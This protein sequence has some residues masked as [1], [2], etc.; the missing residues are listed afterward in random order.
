MTDKT[1][2]SF[3]EQL[4]SRTFSTASAAT[5]LAMPVERRLSGKQILEFLRDHTIA[6]I[7]TVRKDGRPHLTMGYFAMDDEGRF[8]LPALAGTLRKQN[9]V[10]NPHASLLVVEAEGPEHAMVKVEGDATVE[11]EAPATILEQHARLSTGTDW[12]DCFIRVVPLRL[13]SYSA[14]GS[15]FNWEDE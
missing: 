10:V 8:W 13:Y 14:V 11:S 15:R 9:V 2:A 1:L 7:A 12:V 6:A 5:V 3:F 4:Q